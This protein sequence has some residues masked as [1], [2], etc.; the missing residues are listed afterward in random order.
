MLAAENP[1]DDKVRKARKRYGDLPALW[2][3]ITALYASGR[4]DEGQNLTQALMREKA[5]RQILDRGLALPELGRFADGIVEWVALRYHQFDKNDDHANVYAMESMLP[6][7]AYPL[8]DWQK[9]A[10]PRPN[11]FDMTF[12]QAVD[13][14]RDFRGAIPK[15]APSQ[16]PVAYLFADGWTVQ[17]LNT[18]PLLVAE[19]NY[20]SVCVGQVSHGYPKLVADGKIKIYSLRDP[21][22]HPSVTMTWNIER[23]RLTEASGRL[24]E[25]LTAEQ[26]ERCAEFG[27]SMG[28]DVLALAAAQLRKADGLNMQGADLR[29]RDLRNIVLVDCDFRGANLAGALLNDASITLCDFDGANFDGAFFSGSRMRKSKFRGANMRSA[30]LLYS[31]FTGCDLTGAIFDD[32]DM[33]E[34]QAH[35]CLFRNA[36]MKWAN[37]WKVVFAETDLTGADLGGARMIEAKIRDSSL[38]GSNLRAAS[39]ANASIE[40]VELRGAKYN[41]HT[42]WPSGYLRD[43]KKS[44][45]SLDGIGAVLEP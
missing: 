23:G 38:D 36:S 42:F 19:G 7:V 25:H 39:L 40:D 17:D 2:A 41:R 11:I 8:V 1:I 21:E 34:M 4:D 31:V 29:G 43:L 22:G 13:A 32:A 15:K 27:A 35:D 24:N 14:A 26:M 37:M 12:Y 28:M 30:A 6:E 18:T 44:G 5:P 9:K 3:L 20:Q 33:S 16:G 10:R 45:T